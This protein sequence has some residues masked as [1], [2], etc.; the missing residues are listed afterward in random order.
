MINY[1]DLHC[2]TA[3]EI[4]KNNS[5]L[6]KNPAH[7]DIEKSKIFNRYSQIFAIWSENDRGDD[8]NYEDFFRIRSYFLENLCENNIILCKTGEQYRDCI[9]KNLNSAVLAVEGGKLISNDLSRLDV[10]RKS[11]VRFFTLVWSGICAIG[12]AFNTSDGLT[13]FGREVVAKLNGL[14]IIIDISHSSEKMVYETLELTTKPVI[15]SHSNSKAVFNHNR[16]LTDEQFLEIKRTGGIVGIS[17]CSPHV[18]EEASVKDI[19]KHIDYYLSLD[20]EDTVCFGCDFDGAPLVGGIK[21]LADM[22]KFIEE[23][24]KIGYKQ[25]L[26]KK[27]MYGNADNFI[28]NNL[29]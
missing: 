15:A 11:D 6:K 29:K 13:E 23:F 8:E 16:N 12:G 9:E 10:L 14:D 27:I 17:L 18:A 26:I 22:N 21:D 3:L 4:Y 2:D 1:T 19:I 24:E 20:G 25:T 28:I 7:I 5:R